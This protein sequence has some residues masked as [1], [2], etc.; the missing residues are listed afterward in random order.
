MSLHDF[1][2][3]RCIIV[4]DCWE[5]Q[6]AYQVCGATPTINTYDP[7]TGKRRV[8]SVRRLIMLDKYKAN[9]GVMKNKLATY[10]CGNSCCVNPDHI[11][12]A[13][14]QKLQSRLTG[15]HK[16][17]SNPVRNKLLADKSRLKSKLTEEKAQ[18]I[19]EAE[20]TQRQIAAQ[21]GVSQATISCIKRGKT[22]RDYSNPFA[23]LIG[24]LN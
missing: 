8:M 1:I 10:K 7:V 24:G 19:R 13:T 14:R 16:S 18:Q 15:L 20:G 3:D 9:P 5:W 6:N 22:W 4:G 17:Q 21:F 11:E 2:K 12:L 23:Q